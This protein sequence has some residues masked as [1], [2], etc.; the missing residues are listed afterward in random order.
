MADA[1]PET[2]EE[3][4]RDRLMRAMRVPLNVRTSDLPKRAASA[5]VMLLAAGVC[6]WLGGWFVDGLIGAVAAAC[7]WEWQRLVRER[8]LKPFTRAIWY[9][10]GILYI[11]LAAWLLIEMPERMFLLILGVVIGTD[12]FA[13][14]TGRTFGGPKIAPRIS[15]SKTWSGLVGGM[16]GATLG[17]LLFLWFSHMWLAGVL[18]SGGDGVHHDTYLIFG[19]PALFGFALLSGAVLAVVA[20]AGDFFESWMKRKASRKDSSNLIPGHGGVFDR[21]DG[22]L[23]V[24]ITIGLF[25]RYLV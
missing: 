3:R 18:Q 17:L 6:F 10:G 12:T 9:A 20:Q 8:G 22:M 7:Y 1:E 23:P 15:P 16:I 14:F 11:G 5:V 21:V 25:M 19:A 4:R 13:Y 24:A 2:P